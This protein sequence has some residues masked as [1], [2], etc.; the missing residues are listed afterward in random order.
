MVF[1][2]MYFHLNE[3]DESEFVGLIYKEKNSTT[4]DLSGWA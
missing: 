4:S 2:F 1:R 3:K